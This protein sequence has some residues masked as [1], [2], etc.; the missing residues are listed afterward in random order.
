MQV[1]SRVERLEGTMEAQ[2]K[3]FKA[4]NIPWDTNSLNHVKQSSLVLVGLQLYD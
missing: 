2:E 4:N 1:K 3:A